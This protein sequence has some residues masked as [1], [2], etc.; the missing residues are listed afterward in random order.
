MSAEAYEIAL[1]GG[2]V[3][4]EFFTIG[5]REPVNKK[6][7]KEFWGDER[8]AN[9]ILRMCD[10]MFHYK[11]QCATAEGDI[12]RSMNVMLVSDLF[13]IVDETKLTRTVLQVWT[14]TF[15]GSSKS[16]YA[17]E[18]LELTCNFEF[19]YSKELQ[20]AILNN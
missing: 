18:L 1:E 8:L 15:T 9:V 20:H 5:P 12:G 17:N 2:Q 7:K 10:S 13:K 14:Y 4:E 19:E 3:A 11:F 16:K 6:T